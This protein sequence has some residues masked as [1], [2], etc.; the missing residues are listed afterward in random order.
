MTAN[1]VQPEAVP[2]GLLRR[3]LRLKGW[4]PAASSPRAAKAI[5]AEF[6]G[7]AATMSA[8]RGT[9]VRGNFDIWELRE[10]GAG[11]VQVMVPTTD[12]DPDHLER[13]ERAIQTIATVEQ[14]APDLVAASARAVGFDMFNSRIPDAL[15]FDDSIALQIA[16]KYIDDIQELLA[17]TATTEIEPLAFYGRAK[18]D[19]VDF[20]RNCRFAHTFRGSFGFTIESPV[21]ENNTP[22]LPTLDENPPFERKVMQRFARGVRAACMAVDTNDL[23]PITEGVRDGFSANACE[24]FAQLIAD[25]SPGGL[26]MSFSFSP[27]WRTSEDFTEALEFKV[28]AR[29][30]EATRLAAKALRDKPFSRPEIIKGRIVNLHNETDPT[31][32]LHTAGEREITV[33]WMSFDLDDIDV[34][35]ALTPEQYLLAYEAHGRAKEV[36]ATGTLERK[37]REWV[38]ADVTSFVTENAPP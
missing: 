36:T 25:T 2:A 21:E 9:N 16:A 14:R 24:K 26:T 17:A 27:E 20:A 7:F 29:H 8:A 30:A 6:Q 5:P 34:H 31:D 15:V 35:I 12:T 10:P 11:A 38:L 13:I 18:K 28:D 33:H 4:K 37:G 22:A 32:L 19:A 3:Y 1:P 23:K